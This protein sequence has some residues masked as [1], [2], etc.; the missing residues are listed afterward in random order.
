M[1][2]FL[3]GIECGRSNG[4]AESLEPL[5]FPSFLPFVIATAGSPSVKPLFNVRPKC[6]PPRCN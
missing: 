4:S 5:S 6:Y 3:L 1:E 2:R